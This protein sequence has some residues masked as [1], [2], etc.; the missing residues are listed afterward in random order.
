MQKT[1]TLVPNIIPKAGNYM[2]S[3]GKLLKLIR[4][5]RS[6]PQG[7]MANLLG[8][9]QNFLSQVENEKK[10]PSLT[11]LVNFAQRLS[12]SKDIL[13]IAGCEVPP[14][15]SDKDK[16]IFSDMQKS[17]LQILLLDN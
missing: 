6:I 3:I 11:T 15:L 17:A 16:V 14:E 13:F 12:I 9:S 4:V 5:H 1:K 10:Q 7:E 8:V 2:S